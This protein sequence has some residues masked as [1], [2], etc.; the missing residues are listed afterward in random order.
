MVALYFGITVFIFSIKIPTLIDT[1]LS[2]LGEMTTPLSMFIIGARLAVVKRKEILSDKMV[3]YGAFVKLILA[4]V[5]MLIILSFMELP[6]VT[7]GVA[8]IYGSLPPAAM[9][10]ILAKQYNGNTEFSSKTVVIQHIL[11]LATIIFFLTLFL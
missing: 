2:T 1:T 10:V 5:L 9:I 6:T 4:P 3:Y 8:I 11:S 7:R